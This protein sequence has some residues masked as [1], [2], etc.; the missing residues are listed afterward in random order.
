MVA[1][2][3][4]SFVLFFFTFSIS[5]LSTLI[6][7][8]DTKES[9]TEEKLALIEEFCNESGVSTELKKKLKDNVIYSTEKTGG[10]LYDKQ[11]VFMEL[12]RYLRYE[13]SMFMHKGA[14]RTLSFFTDKDPVFVSSIVPFLI[15]QCFQSGDI[16][17][18][19]KDYPEEMYFIVKGRV[20][21]AYGDHKIVFKQLQADSYFGEVELFK[22]INRRFSVKCLEATEVLTLEKRILKDVLVKFP[23]VAVE[24]AKISEERDLMNLISKTE[25]KE[26]EKLRH[27]GEITK[28]THEQLRNH[29][30]IKIKEVKM[31]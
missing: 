7:G 26:I 25:M 27:S 12:P 28:L 23:K 24:M 2:A 18:Q 8:I 4:M 17:F 31:S 20:G 13:V 5:T 15:N 1:I 19:E 9:V 10:S 21:F 22:D 6:S 14:A 30:K 16:I 29:L 11:E 3:W